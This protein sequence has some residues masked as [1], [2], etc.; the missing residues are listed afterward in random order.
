MK[1][2]EQLK[3]IQDELDE[4]QMGNCPKCGSPLVWGTFREIGCLECYY[5]EQLKR[6]KRE[7]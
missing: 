1:T 3:K 2:Y 4:E 6:N 5:K 7:V